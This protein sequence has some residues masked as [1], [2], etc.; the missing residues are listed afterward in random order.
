MPRKR[1]NSIAALQAAGGSSVGITCPPRLA[2]GY[3]L[4][5]LRA[6]VPRRG[7]IS[8]IGIQENQENLPGKNRKNHLSYPAPKGQNRIARGNAPGNGN[9]PKP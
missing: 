4:F 3:Y 9:V 8:A 5:A 6:N 7:K 1:A 2:R